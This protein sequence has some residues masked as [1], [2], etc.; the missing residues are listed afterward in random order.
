MSQTEKEY[1]LTCLIEELAKVQTIT[2][3]T[4]RFGFQKLNQAGELQ[5]TNE[6]MMANRFSNLIAI[7]QFLAFKY[8]P[9]LQEAGV[10][11]EEL[12]KIQ[13]EMLNN[14]ENNPSLD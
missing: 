13:K 10:D 9:L 1:V 3:N 12:E 6:Q 14:F 2:S 11:S 5:L 8:A 7:F 4:L